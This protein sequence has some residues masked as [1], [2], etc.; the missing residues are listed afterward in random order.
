MKSLNSKDET[1][2]TESLWLTD[3][4][5]PNSKLGCFIVAF[6]KFFNDDYEKASDTDNWINHTIK[7]RDWRNKKREIEVMS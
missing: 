6:E 1:I 5:T 7:V 2:Y 4:A 3:T